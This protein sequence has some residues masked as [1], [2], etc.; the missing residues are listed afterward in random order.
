MNSGE[1]DIEVMNKLELLL[2]DIELRK[3]IADRG[4]K[5][6]CENLNPNI[7]RKQFEEQLNRL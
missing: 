5:Y 2:A 1:D 4:Y 3:N 6:V 7:I